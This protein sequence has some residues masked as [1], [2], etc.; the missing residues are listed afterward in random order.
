MEKAERNGM[1]TRNAMPVVGGPVTGP[2]AGFRRRSIGAAALM[3]LALMG[4]AGCRDA[5]TLE[6]AGTV[7]RYHLVPPPAGAAKGPVRPALVVYLHGFDSDDEPSPAEKV[8]RELVLSVAARRGAAV[9]LPRGLVGTFPG[10][11]GL[12]AWGPGRE[13]ENRQFLARLVPE[14]VATHDFD[15]QRV[16]LLGFSSGGYFV[17][18]AASSPWEGFFAGYAAFGAGIRA[19]PDD[20]RSAIADRR[21]VFLGIG[22]SDFRHQNEANEAAVFLARRRPQGSLKVYVY[23]GGHTLTAG[24]LEA[25]FDYLGLEP[26]GPSPLAPFRLPPGGAPEPPAPVPPPP[27][28]PASAPP[29]TPPRGPADPGAPPDTMPGGG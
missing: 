27:S 7:R 21:K 22:R 4:A 5:E 24:A 6:V 9:L 15:P 1:G 23:D 17:T 20:G 18:S 3:A 2:G 25:A 12:L 29:Q 11:P 10:E 19:S 14:V 28:V 16:F 26:H 13:G 8:N